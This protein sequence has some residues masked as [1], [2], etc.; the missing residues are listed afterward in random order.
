MNKRTLYKNLIKILEKKANGFYYTE[1]TAEYEKTQN[2]LKKDV[3]Q[4][5]FLENNEKLKNI[6]RV[7]D[8]SNPIYDTIKSQDENAQ[9]K[10]Q[11]S[12]ELTLTKKKIT[13]HYIPPDML[14]IKT[15]FEIYGQKIKEKKIDDMTDEDLIKLKEKLIGEIIN[16]DSKNL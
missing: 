8:G 1:E 6:D 15:L 7:Y 16:E 4:L 13:T 9:N 3:K 2:I 11:S 5:S 10:T 14:A 12:P